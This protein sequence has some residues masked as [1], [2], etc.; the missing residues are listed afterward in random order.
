VSTTPRTDAL[1][2][3]PGVTL[4]ELAGEAKR[5]EKELAAANDKILR[6][7]LAGNRLAAIVDRDY[8]KTEFTKEWDK[9]KAKP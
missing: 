7:T 8:P 2:F 5:M 4:Y 3:K 1:Y 6:M 9:A